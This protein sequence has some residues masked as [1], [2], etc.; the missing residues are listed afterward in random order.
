MKESVFEQIIAQYPELIEENLKLLG[1]QVNVKGKFVDVLF[2]DRYGQ[3]LVVELKVGTI[4]RKH[5]AQL[6]DYEGHFISPDDP[7]ARVMLV[8]NHI[9]TNLKRSL[10]HHGFEWREIRLPQLIEF[11]KARNDGTFS[12]HFDQEDSKTDKVVIGYPDSKSQLA[13]ESADQVNKEHPGRTNTIPKKTSRQVSR[14]TG[15][16][17]DIIIA[18]LEAGMSKKQVIERCMPIYFTNHP[19]KAKELGFKEWVSERVTRQ[20]VWAEK[21]V[22]GSSSRR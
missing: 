2:E 19:D 18:S 6:M 20:I 12:S 15:S 22:L 5:I 3:K 7:T 4:V 8:G 9:P 11:L 21:N 16:V 17:I 14:G 10:D 13:S 1:R